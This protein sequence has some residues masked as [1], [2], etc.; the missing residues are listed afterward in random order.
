MFPNRVPMEREA[1]FPEPMVYSFIY[2]YIRVPSKE[3]SLEKRGKNLVTVH[4]ASRG[5]KAYIQWGAAWFPKGMSAL[6][7]GF[8]LGSLVY[9]YSI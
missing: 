1:S 2:I 8:C 7:F 3:P 6:E 9:T 5:R 4:E